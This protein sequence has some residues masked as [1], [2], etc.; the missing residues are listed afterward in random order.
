MDQETLHIGAEAKVNLGSWLGRKVVLKKREPKEYRHPSLERRLTRQRLTTEARILTR[1]QLIGFPCPILLNLNLEQG[2]ML[3]SHI[4]GRVLYE[5]LLDGTAGIK[6]IKN[7]GKLIRQLHEAGFSHG[8]LTTHNVI[9]SEDGNL[10]LIDFG[11]AKI[12]PEIEHLGLDLQVLNECLTASH[13]SI[14]NSLDAMIE[15]YLSGETG[16]EPNAKDVIERFNAIRGRVRY[17][18]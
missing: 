16:P 8:D 17:H 6:E 13:Y 3:L 4:D 18:A 15:G 14:E 10:S 1:M 12:S 11:L 5:A 2:W 9:L 7:F